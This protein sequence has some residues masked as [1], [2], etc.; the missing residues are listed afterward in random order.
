MAGSDAR[1][2]WRRTA[3]DGDHDVWYWRSHRAPREA[4]AAHSRF[5]RRDRRLHRV[6]PLDV[7]TREHG[8]RT[9][10]Q[11]RTDRYRLPEDAGSLTSVPR[12]YRKLSIVVA[13]AGPAPGTSGASFWRQRHGVD[14]DRGERGIGG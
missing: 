7:S 8:P 11:R 3:L 5:T 6:H 10:D 13:D 14:H 1:R 9:P 2:S 4:L 12:Q